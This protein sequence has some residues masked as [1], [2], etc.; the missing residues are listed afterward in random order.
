MTRACNEHGGVNLGQGICDVPTPEIVKAGALD[1]VANNRSIYTRYDGNEELR[2]AL[3]EKLAH[4]N[5][6]EANPENEIVV[7]VGSAGAYSCALTA[8]FD[9]GDQIVLFEPFYGYHLNAAR[10]SGLDP[11]CVR[12]EAPT[13]ALDIDALKAAI[14]PKVK[15]ILVNTPM[16]PCGKVF[17]R[18]E[19]AQ[20]AE[21]CIER[22]LI[23]LT[24]EVYEYLVYSGHEHVSMATLP[25]MADRTVTMTSYSKTFSVT[26]WRIGYATAKPALAEAIGLINDLNYICAPHPLQS[27]VAHGIRQL[28]DSYYSDMCSEYEVKRDQ[29]CNTLKKVGLDPIVPEGAYYVLADIRSLGEPTAKAAAMKLLSEAKVAGV[30]GSA[31]FADGGE[32]L[33]RFCYAKRQSDLDQAIENLLRWRG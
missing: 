28:P 1:A 32:H 8:L 22:D 20:I 11:V 5:E 7:T 3:S 18:D 24:D 16:N 33:I 9:P 21:V 29:F 31:F 30:P 4:F 26:G 17:T 25:G 14:G 13:F 12:L 27:A 10:V 6:I 2:T 19:L 23:C 15:G